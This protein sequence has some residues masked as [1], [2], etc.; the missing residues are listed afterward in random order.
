MSS[1]ITC[2]N[3]KLMFKIHVFLCAKFWP[4]EIPFG[5]LKI[6]KI[7]F[8]WPGWP[9]G[10]K[11]KVEPCNGSSGKGPAGG[12]TKQQHQGQT[13]VTSQT[14]EMSAVA[15]HYV[16]GRFLSRAV[17]CFSVGVKIG[18]TEVPCLLD[19]GSQVTAL[20]ETFFMR[21]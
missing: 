9:P 2:N 1:F 20:G 4:P 7:K 5:H 10:K 19:P 14:S 6:E 16:M 12:D 13:P 11:V 17:K 18:C 8:R 3:L 15:G 21:S